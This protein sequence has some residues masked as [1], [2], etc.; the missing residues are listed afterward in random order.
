MLKIQIKTH[1]ISL[2]LSPSVL[3]FFSKR[4]QAAHSETA[5][6]SQ[7]RGQVSFV[8]VRAFALFNAV[9]YKQI[10]NYSNCFKEDATFPHV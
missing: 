4:Y 5:L 8:P 2:Q 9:D 10:K 1:K 6:Q 3:D 7:E